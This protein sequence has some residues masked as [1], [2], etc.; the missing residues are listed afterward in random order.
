[1]WVYMCI[2]IYRLTKTQTN[3]KKSTFPGPKILKDNNIVLLWD[4]QNPRAK[5]FN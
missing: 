3:K 2:Y 5:F 4:F 1:M